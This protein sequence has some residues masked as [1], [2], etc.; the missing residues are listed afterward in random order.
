MGMVKRLWKPAVLC[1]LSIGFVAVS[2]GR[3]CGDFDPEEPDRA[4]FAEE[5]YEILERLRECPLDITEAAIDDFLDIP[6]FPRSLAEKIVRAREDGKGASLWLKS[7]TPLELERLYRYEEFCLLPRR[8][9]LRLT[10][11]FSAERFGT[12]GLERR[13]AFLTCAG[14]GYGGSARFRSSVDVVTVSGCVSKRLLGGRVVIHGWDFVPD[15]AMG[16]LFDGSFTYY[17]FTSGYPFRRYRTVAARTSF[18]PVAVR[19][20][21]VESYSGGAC[22]LVFAGRPRTWR[23]DRFCLGN[24]VLGGMRICRRCASWELGASLCRD[25]AHDGGSLAGVDGRCRLGSMA[26]GGEMACGAAGSVSGV[27][28]I[29]FRGEV[30]DIG[31]LLH[32]V[33]FSHAG[34]FGAAAGRRSDTDEAHRG[35]SVVLGRW[36]TG[37]CRVRAAFEQMRIRERLGDLRR[38]SIRVEMERRR[39]PVR[40]RVS[41]HSRIDRERSGFI[42]PG[43]LIEGEH[44]SKVKLSTEW[45]PHRLLS[46]GA[47]FQYTG[48]G[49]GRGSCLAPS[50]RLMGPSGSFD[51]ML[52]A[53]FYGS[54]AGKAVFSVYEP[55]LEGGY[56]WKQLYGSGAAW[57]FR[58]RISVGVMRFSWRLSGCDDGMIEGNVQIGLKL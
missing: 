40:V 20:V 31:M 33:S 30:F 27:W 48:S 15:I 35:F 43:S 58:S 5:E 14:D 18:Y 44:L 32:E 57:V 50:I 11:R 26:I 55:A 46:F 56:P 53:A 12:N 7:L 34:R 21:A 4:D 47:T 8:A 45:R 36:D 1:M 24:A 6:G 23:G 49:C 16:L 25:P 17:P 10:G 29:R 9:P 42:H 22:I 52:K 54:Y 51:W 2:H 37:G 28:G 38:R 3:A 41:F 39:R 19:G 13:Q